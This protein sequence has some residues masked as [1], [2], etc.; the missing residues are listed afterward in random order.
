MGISRPEKVKVGAEIKE[1]GDAISY[2]YRAISIPINIFVCKDGAGIKPAPTS[3]GNPCGC[4]PFYRDAKLLDRVDI[5][6][7][8]EET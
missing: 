4:P 1:S 5:R 6:V 3:R 8:K 2:L 7:R